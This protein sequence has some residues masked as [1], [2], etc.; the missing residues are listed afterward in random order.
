M[1]KQATVKS[2]DGKAIIVK[3]GDWIGFK[4]DIEQSGQIIE[5]R[6]SKTLGGGYE[7]VLENKNGFS[8]GYIGGATQTIEH[9]NDCWAE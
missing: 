4:C 7:F 3:V 1:I 5:I 9:A 8:G 6:R 2:F